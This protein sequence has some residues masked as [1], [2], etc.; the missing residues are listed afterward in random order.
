MP[1]PVDVAYV[2]S[3]EAKLDVAFPLGFVARMVLENGGEIQIEGDLWWLHPFLD[4]SDKTRLKR[5][6]NDIVRETES[7]R[8]WRGFPPNAVAIAANGTG[9]QLIL[10]PSP[11]QPQRLQDAVFIWDHET[12]EVSQIADD[13]FELK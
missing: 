12:G 3:A 11:P 7:A 6:C 2:K 1:F 4:T 8:K 9:D 10:L 13:F 5:T